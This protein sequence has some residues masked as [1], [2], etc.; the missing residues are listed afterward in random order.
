MWAW[1]SGNRPSW[2]AVERVEVKYPPGLCDTFW[3][4]KRFSPVISG[5]LELKY[6]EPN[7][8]Q[9]RRGYLPKLRREQPL[10]LRRQAEN[11]VPCGILLRVGLERWLLWQGMSDHKWVDM[12]HSKY[13]V[14]MANWTW[15]FQWLG[16][17]DAIER[18]ERPIAGRTWQNEMQ[19]VPSAG[20]PY[21]L[22]P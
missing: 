5:W 21:V 8:E 18:L 17:D 22:H 4:D 13:A 9:Y 1:V 3:T 2:L 15:E 19:G 14:E 6:C 10:F 12:M 11:G 7:D 20:N 16:L